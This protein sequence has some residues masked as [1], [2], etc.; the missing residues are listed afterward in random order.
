MTMDY[1]NPYARFGVN[2]NPMGYPQAPVPGAVP[3]T[4]QQPRQVTRVKG[5]DGA[6]S[7][8]SSLPPNS[9]DVAFDCDEDVFYFISTDGGGFPTLKPCS[10]TQLD[11]AKPGNDQYVTHDELNSVVSSIKEMIASAQ[12][13]VSSAEP[14]AAPRQSSR[15]RK[16]SSADQP[17]QAALS[18]V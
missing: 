8:A 7:Y 17:A 3:G 15:S 9:T 5:M 14:A 18:G 2:M 16:S 13:P 6:K 12:Q 4:W 1:N 10:F 11:Q